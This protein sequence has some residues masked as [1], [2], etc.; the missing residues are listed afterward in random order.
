[1]M[2]KGDVLLCCM[3]LQHNFRLYTVQIKFSNETNFLWFQHD[4][5]S[6]S[7]LIELVSC[8]KVD[9]CINA[10]IIRNVSNTI[11]PLQ[12]TALKYLLSTTNQ[13]KGLITL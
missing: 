3:L 2:L 9:V 8:Q 11:G 13:G 4:V 7:F 6:V 12:L 1:M 10:I 5:E